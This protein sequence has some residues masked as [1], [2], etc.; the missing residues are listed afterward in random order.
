M[1][2][3][4]IRSIPFSQIGIAI[5]KACFKA[6]WVAPSLF[7]LGI[8]AA[9]KSFDITL[10]E[11]IFVFIISGIVGYFV[12]TLYSFLTLPIITSQVLVF[13]KSH[14]FLR[15]FSSASFGFFVPMGM[16]SYVLFQPTLFYYAIVFSA[17]IQAIIVLVLYIKQLGRSLN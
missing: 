14:D 3:S 1:T 10:P 11:A 9:E 7:T 4:Q 6:S 2:M 12:S 8:V 13:V 5:F 15:S 16:V 17:W